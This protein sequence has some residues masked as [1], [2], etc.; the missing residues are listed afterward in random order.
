AVDRNQIERQQRAI[1]QL[2][3][4]VQGLAGNLREA[5]RGGS[6]GPDSQRLEQDLTQLRVLTHDTLLLLE[7]LSARLDP[8]PARKGKLLS[9][10]RGVRREVFDEGQ[11][12]GLTELGEEEQPG[13]GGRGGQV[14]LF[15]EQ[16]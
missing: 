2:T 9:T 10:E 12:S 3:E 15:R 1:E 5:G 8:I 16:S 13:V 6:G 7:Q 11:E 4:A 14:R